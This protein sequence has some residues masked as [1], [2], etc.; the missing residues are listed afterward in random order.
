MMVK[1]YK[2]QIQNSKQSIIIDCAENLLFYS[3]RYDISNDKS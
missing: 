3:D 2:M 1:K